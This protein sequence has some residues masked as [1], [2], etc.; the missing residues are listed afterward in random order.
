MTTA[1]FDPRE[2]RADD[3]T[4]R[5]REAATE[6]SLEALTALRELEEA[7][8]RR[9]RT[10]VL[11]ALDAAVAQMGELPRDE[12]PEVRPLPPAPFRRVDWRGHGLCICH[13]CGHQEF[14]VGRAWEHAR[15]HHPPTEN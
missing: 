11:T 10:S 14:D 3:V 7:H 15:V 6:L 5:L 13:V 9:P 8:P 2:L 12:V 4:R 1:P